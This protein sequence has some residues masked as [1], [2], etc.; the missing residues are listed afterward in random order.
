MDSA[1]LQLCLL[2]LQAPD[3]ADLPYT[4]TQV[5]HGVGTQT[6]IQFFFHLNVLIIM[7]A[8]RYTLSLNRDG[9]ADSKAPLVKLSTMVFYIKVLQNPDA[10]LRSP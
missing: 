9:R 1:F 7:P 2:Q 5:C 3:L 10:K 6:R 8:R 4:I